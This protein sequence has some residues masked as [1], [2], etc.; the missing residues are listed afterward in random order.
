MT[1][2]WTYG[3]F[4]VAIVALAC[5]VH[6]PRAW[7]WIGL[8]GLS[9][10][11][12]TLFQD[13]AGRPDLQ[14]FVTLGCDALVCWAIF[15]WHRETWEIGVYTAFLC[16]TFA[17]LLFIG[18]KFEHWVYASLLEIANL[19]ALLCII[20]TGL[21]DMV[22]RNANSPVHLVRVHLR[23]AHDHVKRNDRASHK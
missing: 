19:A 11:V 13:Y 15:R 22:G 10:F 18:F 20:G 2:L 8:G 5:S 16:S 14:P 9:F 3:L 4:I 23:H 17:S 6:V 7:R 1:S 12:S 21:I